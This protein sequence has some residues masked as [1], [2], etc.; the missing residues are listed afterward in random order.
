MEGVDKLLIQEALYFS[1]FKKL[2][3]YFIYISN[4]IPKVPH[5]LPYPLPH[6]LPHPPTP[7]SWLWR[8][9]ELRQQFIW[10]SLSPRS[11]MEKV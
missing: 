11:E 3:I 7:T 5:T 9:P 1:F 10:A 2:G 8:S 6:P 4:T